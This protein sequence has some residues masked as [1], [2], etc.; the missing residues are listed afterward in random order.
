MFESDIMFA[1]V[2]DVQHRAAQRPLLSLVMQ[3]QGQRA[4]SAIK[5]KRVETTNLLLCWLSICA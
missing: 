3:Q 5:L 1:S 2:H 4:M